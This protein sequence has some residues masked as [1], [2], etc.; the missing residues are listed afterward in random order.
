MDFNVFVFVVECVRIRNI[1][2]IQPKCVWWLLF[3]CIPI[4][5]VY[6][7]AHSD[8]QDIIPCVH[9]SIS[10]IFRCHILCCLYEA[11]EWCMYVCECFEP[12]LQV[13]N[14]SAWVYRLCGSLLGHHHLHLKRWNAVQLVYIFFLLLQTA[15]AQL[16]MFVA[17]IVVASNEL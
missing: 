9:I 15:I 5:T 13:N 11:I 1:S 3:C 8:A 12:M 2:S 6:G 17:W 14:S 10:F 7:H 16:F 4:N